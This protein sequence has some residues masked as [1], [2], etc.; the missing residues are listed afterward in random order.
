MT[1][2]PV[3]PTA[4]GLPPGPRWPA[5]LSTYRFIRSRKQV[6][7]ELHRR[8][9]DPF[10]VRIL[11]G[12]RNLVV[13]SDPA[14]IK[15]VFASDPHDFHAGEGNQILEPVMGPRS[16]LLV[17]DE[18]HT[19]ARRLLMPAFT[20]PALRGYRTMV[21]EIAA[22]EVATWRDGEVVPTLDRMNAITLNVILRVVFGVT[23]GARL[24]ALRPRVRRMVNVGPLLLLGWQYARASNLPPWRGYFRNQDRVD[25]ILYDEIAERREAGDIDDRS[26]VLSRLLRAGHD[27]SDTEVLSDAELR[28]QLVTLL[29]AG[30]ETTA[31]ALSWTLHE[32]G[33]H[34]DLRKRA[35]AAADAGDDT[36]LEAC[37][38][39][40]MRLHPIID[41]VAR[42]LKSDQLVGGRL[43][44]K[45]TVVTPSIMLSHALNF[46]D[47]DEFRPDRFL[48]GPVSHN[49]WI[50]FGGGVRRCIGAAFSLMEG[51]AILG[52]ILRHF[53]FEADAP[54]SNRLRNI[55]NVPGDGA[56]L[57]LRARS[58]N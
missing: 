49:I 5:W 46:E 48:D 57:R 18:E 20:G 4:V 38:K 9:G 45:G 41:F 34:P 37:M 11:P 23:D 39:E 30:H 55:T 7:P 40:A 24:D 1:S 10:T 31:S 21:D 25:A 44:P 17:D 8:F 36:F 2:T 16:L 58:G 12:P 56:P 54:A 13:I 43:L 32:L 22:A 14:V 33:R 53:D 50:P 47:A 52:E 6:M 27:D 42:R 28:D 29:M 35:I 15:E 51:A 26:D 19:R 3:A